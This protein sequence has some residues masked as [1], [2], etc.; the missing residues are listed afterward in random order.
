MH[1]NA[2]ICTHAYN[3]FRK[4]T[5]RSK[6]LISQSYHSTTHAITHAGQHTSNITM[7]WTTLL[8][9]QDKRKGDNLLDQ[10]IRV[11]YSLCV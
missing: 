11:T 5:Y 9:L 6:H 4:R 3:S 8:L 2:Y 10:V 7:T 1:A